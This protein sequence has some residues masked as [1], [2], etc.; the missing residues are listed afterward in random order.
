M[1]FIWSRIAVRASVT[2]SLAYLLCPKSAPLPVEIVLKGL[3]VTLLA[4][5]AW[6]AGRLLLALALLLSSAGD[7]LLACGDRFF[8]PGLAAFLCAHL[9]YVAVFLHRGARPAPVLS[10]F[11]LP[12]AVLLYGLAFGAWLAPS[13]GPLRLPVFC[14]IAAI[15]AMVAAAYRANYRS[16]LVLLGAL[17]FLLSDSLLGANRFKTAIPFAGFLIWTTYYAGQFALARGVW[18]VPAV[19]AKRTR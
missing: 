6:G 3:S 16:R 4:A 13:L 1:S 17:L 19:H 18:S 15:L 11:A 10:R 14:Y 12:L 7:V 8:V 2:A 5:A 9:V